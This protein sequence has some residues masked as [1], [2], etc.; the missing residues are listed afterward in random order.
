MA[1][2]AK[3]TSI[4]LTGPDDWDEWIGVI[5]TKAEAAEIWPFIDPSITECEELPTLEKRKVPSPADV[6]A[7][8]NRPTVTPSSS[9][10]NDPNA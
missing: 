8:R 2:S 10:S 7:E 5:Q 1:T 9:S 6:I 3:V 4:I